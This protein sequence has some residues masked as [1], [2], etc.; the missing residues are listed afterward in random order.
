[1][2]RL[3]RGRSLRRAP[4]VNPGVEPIVGAPAVSHARPTE[5]NQ[6]FLASLR[7]NAFVC[8]LPAF[9]YA[10][11]VSSK[12]S[13]VPGA[14]LGPATAWLL[15]LSLPFFVF[16]LLGPSL[17]LAAERRLRGGGSGSWLRLA[18]WGGVLCLVWSM[19]FMGF[20]GPAVLRAFLAVSTGCASVSVIY[21]TAAHSRRLNERGVA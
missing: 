19:L 8:L 7:N 17:I 21:R 5:R 16:L 4:Q 12:I 18:F 20:N 1:V 6:R 9:T 14:L 13:A 15:L 2:V 3:L 11:L 10:G